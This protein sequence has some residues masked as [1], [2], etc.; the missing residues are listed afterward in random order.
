MGRDDPQGCHGEPLREIGLMPLIYPD[1][2]VTTSHGTRLAP[3]TISDRGI[4]IYDLSRTRSSAWPTCSARRSS[5]G[6]M[7]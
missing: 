1:L 4:P 2:S 3:P 7:R 5:A 6:I